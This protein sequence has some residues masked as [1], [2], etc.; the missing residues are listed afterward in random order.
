MFRVGLLPAAR[1]FNF[2]VCRRRRPLGNGPFPT[3]PRISDQKSVFGQKKEGDRGVHST[4]HSGGI[5]SGLWK[6][7]K[8]NSGG[9]YGIQ[10]EKL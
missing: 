4:L 9:G 6:G 10:R 7:Q 1:K 2:L 3:L 5:F 8:R